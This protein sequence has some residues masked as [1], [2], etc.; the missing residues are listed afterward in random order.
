MTNGS[1]NFWWK[2]YIGTSIIQS[3]YFEFGIKMVKSF[4]SFLQYM[5]QSDWAKE[6]NMC[7]HASKSFLKASSYFGFLTKLSDRKL[8]ASFHVLLHARCL[9]PAYSYIFC[10]CF[11]SI[12]I[13][14]A[15]NPFLFTILNQFKC[16][17]WNIFCTKWIQARWLLIASLVRKTLFSCNSLAH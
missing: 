6:T 10:F 14:A 1:S 12:S 3:K 9:Q 8:R 16:I 11:Y 5:T 2:I 4:W 7:F 13:V 17:L 15:T